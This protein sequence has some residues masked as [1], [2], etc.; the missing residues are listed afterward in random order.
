MLESGTKL[1][2]SQNCNEI[3]KHVNLRKKLLCES[4]LNNKYKI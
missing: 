2:N 4:E 1:N 3:C